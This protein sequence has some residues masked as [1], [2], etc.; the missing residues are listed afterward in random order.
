MI[1]RHY[2]LSIILILS[3]HFF[4]KGQFV[5]SIN[6]NN[7]NADVYNRGSIFDEGNYIVPKGFGQNKSTIYGAGQWI[8]GLSN[9]QLYLA[10]ETYRQQG[11]DF[12]PGPVMANYTTASLAYWNRIWKITQ[13]NI[14]NFKKS[15]S[16]GESVLQYEDILE[17][18]AKGNVKFGD[19]TSAYAPFVDMN[20]NG[21]YEPLLGEYPQIKGDMALYT[22]INDDMIHSES[23]GTKLQ[24]EIHRLVYGF[25]ADNDAVY[26]SV[27]VDIKIINKSSRNYDSLLFA[28]WVDFDLGNYQDD[29]IGTD[30]ARNMIYAYNGSLADN[31]PKGYGSTPP[32]QACVMLNS[33]LWSSMYYN[34]TS[35]AITGNPITPK[36]HFNYMGGRWKNGSSK[37]ASG[38]GVASTG[39]PTRFSFSGDPCLGTG[40]W[41]GGE[42]ITPG[43]RRIMATMSPQKMLVGGELNYTMAFVYS[44]ADNGNN[45]ASV[46]KLKMDVDSVINWYNMQG[47]NYSSIPETM[48]EKIAF[49]L[50]PNPA[51]QSFTITTS[52]NEIAKITLFDI[53]GRELL[54]QDFRSESTI[55][56][57]EM[58]PG[59]YFV[60]V[61]N[62]SGKSIKKLVI[63]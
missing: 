35:D 30:T 58:K 56:I 51:K 10:A 47:F 20:G 53:S 43:D 45:I 38:I 62:K 2:L 3:I 63:E 11:N 61:Q 40:W 32:A 28:S 48:N 22:I 14:D 59:I 4:V 49:L 25:A 46:C 41:E 18:P 33:K 12:Q 6:I 9:E 29:F 26:N 7:V 44:R 39:Q 34:N 42:N 15:I 19:S 60:Q 36:D 54:N 23:G 57:R 27:F 13:K 8:G 31:G 55:D 16:N 21:K 1:K 37:V 50:Y 52:D 5:S 17:W 24:V